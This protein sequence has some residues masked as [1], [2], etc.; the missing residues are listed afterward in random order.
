[1][2]SVCPFCKQEFSDI[3]DEY[4]GATV[5]CSV[6]QQEFVCETTSEELKLA[7]NF[8]QKQD[9]RLRKRRTIMVCAAGVAVAVILPIL[10]TAYNRYLHWRDCR[11]LNEL[12]T[13]MARQYNVAYS[14]MKSVIVKAKNNR[15]SP[16]ASSEARKHN[17][18]QFVADYN[19]VSPYALGLSAIDGVMKENLQVMMLVSEAT[20]SYTLLMRTDWWRKEIEGV[21]G[22]LEDLK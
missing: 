6:C 15:L 22:P 21:F 13:K 1:M 11:E 8:A 17:F 3:P 7:E 20:D 5:K 10:P 14:Q 9:A 12:Q 2:K 16:N 18:E 19:A 4:A